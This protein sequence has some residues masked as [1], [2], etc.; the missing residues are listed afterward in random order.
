MLKESE[1][2]VPKINKH[3]GRPKIIRRHKS[4]KERTKKMR[5]CSLCN[6][7]AYHN[8]R[9]C[10]ERFKTAQEDP[11]EIQNLVDNENLNESAKFSKVNQ[12]NVAKVFKKRKKVIDVIYMRNEKISQKE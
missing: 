10:P 8:K 1:I 6:K 2:P 3:P 4:I 7:M 9:T 5:K 12:N 11:R